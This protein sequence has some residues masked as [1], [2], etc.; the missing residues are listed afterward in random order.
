MGRCKAAGRPWS[1]HIEFRLI[2][3]CGPFLKFHSNKFVAVF[4]AGIVIDNAWVSSNWFWFDVEF[5]SESSLRQTSFNDMIC[6]TSPAGKD[7]EIFSLVLADL[8][9]WG[10]MIGGSFNCKTSNT[11][12]VSCNNIYNKPHI[13]HNNANK[14]LISLWEHTSTLLVSLIVFLGTL[15]YNLLKS[16]TTATP[17]VPSFPC[18][19]ICSS[20]LIPKIVALRSCFWSKHN[21]NSGCW[22]CCLFL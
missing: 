21:E 9:Q 22:S 7:L 13:H 6:S 14:G 8:L 15:K 3:R 17:R 5:V 4:F 1:R 20:P 16:Q 18:P 2:H 12:Y 19:P 10:G 11:K